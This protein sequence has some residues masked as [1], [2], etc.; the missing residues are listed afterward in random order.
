[1]DSTTTTTEVTE[2]LKNLEK[3]LANHIHLS[4]SDFYMDRR[5]MRCEIRID[6]EVFTF[7]DPESTK[8]A[9]KIILK[10]FEKPLAKN[11]SR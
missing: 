10:R 1:M 11:R 7:Y 5:F 4:I 9:Q 8:A 3:A 2:K 6:T